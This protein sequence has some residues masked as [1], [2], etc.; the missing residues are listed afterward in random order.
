MCRCCAYCMILYDAAWWANHLLLFQNNVRQWFLGCADYF[1]WSSKATGWEQNG[2]NLIKYLWIVAGLWYTGLN[3]TPRFVLRKLMGCVILLWSFFDINCFKW[4]TDCPLLSFWHKSFILKTLLVHINTLHPF[5]NSTYHQLFEQLMQHPVNF[6]QAN[7][8][9]NN[10]ALCADY[11]SIQFVC[12]FCNT[13][14]APSRITMRLIFIRALN[15]HF[16][17]YKLAVTSSHHA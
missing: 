1:G 17:C 2:R 9:P 8:W 3:V 15:T 14:L 6:Y 7:W 13:C 4:L 10:D 12:W 16:L 11:F 5:D